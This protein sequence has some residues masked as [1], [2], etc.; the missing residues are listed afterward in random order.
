MDNMLGLNL[1]M[2]VVVSMNGCCVQQEADTAVGRMIDLSAVLTRHQRL[3]S[4]A[5][6]KLQPAIQVTGHDQVDQEAAALCDAIDASPTEEP[7]MESCCKVRSW[8][9][10]M[11]L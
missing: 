8:T 5:K 10:R 7:E 4:R 1:L 3:E 2:N 6:R 11:E 9:Q